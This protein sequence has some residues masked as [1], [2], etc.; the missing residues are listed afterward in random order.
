MH[1]RSR[2]TRPFPNR[3][4]QRERTKTCNREDDRGARPGRISRKSPGRVTYPV[5]ESAQTIF[6]GTSHLDH[7]HSNQF[8]PIKFDQLSSTNFGDE[9]PGLSGQGK[10]ERAARTT[11]AQ[12]RKA[13]PPHSSRS[14]GV[15]PKH[16]QPEIH[17]QIG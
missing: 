8:R 15:S 5:Q 4:Q 3:A 11:M 13:Y 17:S 7:P 1:R 16:G 10:S 6:S 9:P 14:Q 12:S 2:S